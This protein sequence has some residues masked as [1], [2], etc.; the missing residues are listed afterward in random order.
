M[1]EENDAVSSSSSTCN[2]VINTE[3]DDVLGFDLHV[4]V[5]YSADSSGLV[6]SIP[7]SDPP[8][9][10]YDQLYQPGF[11]QAN[12]PASS[13]ILST[14]LDSPSGGEDADVNLPQRNEFPLAVLRR[15]VMQTIFGWRE[16]TAARS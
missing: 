9:P 8:P 12:R 14:V 5:E 3:D 7:E 11:V 15:G 10:S 4:L 16:G 1:L 6:T 13:E 2:T